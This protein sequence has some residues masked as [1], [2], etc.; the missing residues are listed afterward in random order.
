MRDQAN[1]LV[2]AGH[3][4]TIICGK[5][6]NPGETYGVLVIPELAPDFP[7]NVQVRA[8]L[9]RGQADQSFSR[10]RALLVTVLREALAGEELTLVH[11]VFTMHHNLALTRA[12]HDI[13]PTQRMMAW[14]HDLVATNPDYSLPNPNQP[15]WNL[16]RLANPLVPY[17]TTSGARAN[18]I[19]ARLN[20][21]EAPYV[22]PNPVDPTRL[23]GLTEEMAASYETLDL[24]SRDFIF[25]LPAQTM[26]RKNLDFAI[27]IVRRLKASDRNPLLL[28]TGATV[29]DNSASERY[30]AF[31]RQS[32][33]A[34]LRTHVVFVN[35]FFPVG[36]A[37][38]RDLYLLS[39]CLLFPSRR[40]GFGLPVIEAAWYRLP[41]WCQDIPAYQE[42]ANEGSAFLLDDVLQLAEGVSWLENQPAFRQQRHCRRLFDPGIIYRDFYEPMLVSFAAAER[43]AG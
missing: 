43:Q 8:V 36:D 26:P 17:V 4:V 15:P 27:E 1:M 22:V 30:G 7:L 12:L 5:G 2:R 41:I 28:I 40:E 31:L 21:P 37:T 35:D 10:Y 38:L 6:E 42:M 13:A 3:Q 33:P 32:L 16:M 24:P 34:E 20:L 9:E 25:L 29:P 11:N 18:E 14:T 19:M 39:D 23:F